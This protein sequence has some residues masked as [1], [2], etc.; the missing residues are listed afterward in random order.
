MKTSPFIKAVN[1]I[2]SCETVAQMEMAFKYLKYA[3][4]YYKDHNETFR[5]LTRIYNAKLEELRK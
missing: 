4:E 3:G 1:I 5:I 2:Q